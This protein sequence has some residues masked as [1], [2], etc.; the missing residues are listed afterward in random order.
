MAEETTTMWADFLGLG[1]FLKMATEP[2]MVNEVVN[3]MRTMA[4]NARAAQRIEQ[5]LDFI[6]EGLGHDPQRFTVFEQ[7]GTNGVGGSSVAG[8]PPHDGALR[9]EGPSR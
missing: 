4:D 3:L 5:K 7:H 6:L 2:R 1:P 9:I 8:G